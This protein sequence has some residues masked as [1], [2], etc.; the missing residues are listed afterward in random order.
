M[1]LII[2]WHLFQVLVFSYYFFLNEDGDA[3][4][5]QTMQFDSLGI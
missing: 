5:E 2:F 3:V 1:I 4:V